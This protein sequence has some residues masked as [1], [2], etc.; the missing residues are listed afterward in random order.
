LCKG[1]TSK[2][3][4]TQGG[5]V[6]CLTTSLE[7]FARLSSFVGSSGKAS[8]GAILPKSLTCTIAGALWCFGVAWQQ[9]VFAGGLVG[10]DCHA[11]HTSAVT[12]IDAS[13]ADVDF[14]AFAFGLCVVGFFAFEELAGFLFA[15]LA[16]LEVA[17]FAIT[18]LDHTGFDGVAR[19]GVGVLDTAFARWAV[20]WVG[21]GFVAACFA[22]GNTE[23]KH[24]LV[25]VSAFLSWDDALGADF[26][27]LFD[28]AGRFANARR[29]AR[30]WAKG[31]VCLAKTA[32][33][34][35]ALFSGFDR[36]DTGFDTKWFFPANFAAGTIAIF[37]AFLRADESVLCI[38]HTKQACFAIALLIAAWCGAGLSNIPAIFG[39]FGAFS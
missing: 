13:V 24:S 39:L 25:A 37:V 14:D 33:Q 19:A 34:W 8:K 26:A 9:A 28:I 31:I 35:V 3:T 7:C 23:A 1:D 36:D 12:V 20:A 17:D 30:K 32:L 16:F 18:D 29:I 2:A 22:V 38:L 27:E 5:G 11:D 4:N 10:I 15:H 6:E 21:A